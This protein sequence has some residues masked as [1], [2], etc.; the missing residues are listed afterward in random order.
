MAN[1]E[2]VAVPM[3]YTLQGGPWDGATINSRP[4]DIPPPFVC[5]PYSEEDGLGD[6][7]SNDAMSNVLH[8]HPY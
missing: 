2:A 1:D 8:W 5:A 7:R 6:Y 4:F 3:K